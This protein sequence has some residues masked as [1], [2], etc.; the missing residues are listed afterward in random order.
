MFMQA[1]AQT[2]TI[3]PAFAGHVS[4]KL[5][6]LSGDLHC[7]FDNLREIARGDDPKANGYDRI[8][9]L[10]ILYDR[11]MRQSYKEPGPDQRERQ[12]QRSRSQTRTQARRRQ[13]A[14][15]PARGRS[16]TTHSDRPRP[17]P[18]QTKP[19]TRGWVG[20]SVLSLAEG[21]H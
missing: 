16:S 8:R 5:R 15:R 18:S 19:P 6:E 13:T 10:K 14:G 20:S 9:A 4:D 3:N 1:E 11:G 7:V 12:R 2:G 21:L 17:P